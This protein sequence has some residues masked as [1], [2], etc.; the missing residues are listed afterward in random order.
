MARPDIRAWKRAVAAAGRTQAGSG[1]LEAARVS[2]LLLLARS[3]TM[4]HHRLAALR[5]LAAVRIQ[6]DVPPAHWLY[7]REQ[8]FCSPDPQVRSAYLKAELLHR[9]SASS[10]AA[11]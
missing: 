4:G 11:G 8:A 2:A 5:L 6:A 10:M 1:T 7:C 3:V 9:E